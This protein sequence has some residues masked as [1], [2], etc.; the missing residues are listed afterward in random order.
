[1]RSHKKPYIANFI[2]YEDYSEPGDNYRV[3]WCECCQA[4]SALSCLCWKRNRLSED[5][6]KMEAG[7]R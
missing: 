7:S 3:P 1:M 6:E 2:D 4:Y 5:S